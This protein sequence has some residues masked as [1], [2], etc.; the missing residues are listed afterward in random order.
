MSLHIAKGRRALINTWPMPALTAGMT[1]ES[2][3]RVWNEDGTPA[4]LATATITAKICEWNSDTVRASMTPTLPEPGLIAWS[5]A[6]G[7][8]A[9]DATGTYR[10]TLDVT[11]SSGERQ[12]LID[13]ALPVRG[14]DRRRDDYGSL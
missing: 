12:R 3:I 14:N 7:A 10:F 5:F 1:W 9:D 11:L 4:D 13:A 2:D 6:P 8:L